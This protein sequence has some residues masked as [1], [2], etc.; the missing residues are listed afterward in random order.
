[1]Y[2]QVPCQKETSFNFNN[3][4]ILHTFKLAYFVTFDYNQ[5]HQ[6]VTKRYT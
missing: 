4:H 5:K 3:L 2:K 1:M 6:N